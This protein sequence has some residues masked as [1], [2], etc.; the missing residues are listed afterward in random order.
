MGMKRWIDIDEEGWEAHINP[1]KESDNRDEMIRWCRANIGQEDLDWKMTDRPGV[2]LF[3]T[4]EDAVL[5]D[6]TWG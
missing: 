5:F 6:L 3:A 1:M 2:W 4:E